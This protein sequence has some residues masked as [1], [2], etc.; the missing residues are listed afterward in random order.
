VAE[1]ANGN[2]LTIDELAQATG[3]TVRN[4]RAHQSRGLLPPPAVRA[5]T[6]YYGPEHVS[7]LK[8]IHEMQADGFNLNSI[9]RLLDGARGRA[10]EELLEF[11]R[12]LMTPFESEQPEVIDGAELAARWGGVDPKLVA[13]AEKLG[14]IVPLG[15][16]RYEVPSPVLMRAGEEVV[17]LGVPLETAL[18]VTEKLTRH[19]QGVADAFVNL[20]LE[21]VWGPFQEAGQPEERWPEVR[22][23]LERLRPLASEALLAVFRQTMTRAVED[24]FGKELQ[25]KG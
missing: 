9:K 25:R 14:V 10:G 3:M 17:G 23:A 20:F 24:A 16:D 5:R 1:S 7:R 13:K 15:E 6:G 19:S 8:L 22:E 2:E 11:R 21:H 12:A 4:I 18:E